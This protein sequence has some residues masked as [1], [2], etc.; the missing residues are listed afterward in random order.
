MARRSQSG[1]ASIAD[2][3]ALT[4]G[5]L[6]RR[7]RR[8][9]HFSQEQ[10]ARASKV[11]TA[12]SV[13]SDIER[14]I[15]T[16]RDLVSALITTLHNNTPFKRDELR[17][18]AVT[19]LEI[20]GLTVADER[21]RLAVVPGGLEFSTFWT[22]IIAQLAIHMGAEFNLSLH[23]HYEDL[24]KEQAVLETLIEQAPL[25]HGIIWAPAEG[26]KHAPSADE[27]RKRYSAI[28]ALQQQGVPIVAIDRPLPDGAQRAFLHPVP[29]VRGDHAAAAA[30]GIA[31]LCD[32][33]HRRI[34]ILL[35]L[36]H[37]VVQQQRLDGAKREMQARGIA[38]E[39]IAIA[40]G[41]PE[42]ANDHQ[43]RADDT[44]GFH[45]L[46][47]SAEQLLEAGVTGILCTTSY[48]TVEAYATIT[49][50]YRWKIPDDVSLVGFDTVGE[51]TRLGIVRVPYDPHDV[52]L[53]ALEVLRQFH[54]KQRSVEMGSTADV[55]VPLPK[56][57]GKWGTE[58]VGPPR[59]SDTLTD[60]KSY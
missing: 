24:K 46:R 16:N 3:Y 35:D 53:K 23:P 18:L 34:G 26:R 2:H 57:R 27:L 19:F 6:L 51:L 56:D 30:Q 28:K 42:A 5:K 25:L 55:F 1:Q 31:R 50:K 29:V 12:R 38:P 14:G 33:G 4:F 13:V 59:Q 48:A 41:N 44:Q 8:D 52:T 40:W 9:R 49:R 15:K 39:D 60:S 37:G 7:Y 32:A 36:E 54:D 21:G 17:Q 58:T 47:L 45:D 10:L 22:H 43:R 20:D 11:V